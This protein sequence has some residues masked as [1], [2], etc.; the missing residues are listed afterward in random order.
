MAAENG[1][2]AERD[3]LLAPNQHNPALPPKNGT[4]NTVLWSLVAVVF[5]SMSYAF[6][7]APGYRLY[8]VVICKRYYREHVPSVI[9]SGDDIPEENCKIDSIQQELAILLAKQTQI[10]L[11][12]CT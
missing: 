1:F 9:G 12:A 8:E 10:N 5:I 6:I 2:P 7:E 4:T 3:P 11:W